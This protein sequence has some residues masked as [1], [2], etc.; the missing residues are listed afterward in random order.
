M[1]LLKSLRRKYEIKPFLLYLL[2]HKWK[3]QDQFEVELLDINIT[4]LLHNS[5]PLIDVGIKVIGDKIFICISEKK[6]KL[7]HW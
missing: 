1:L 6:D 5:H 4:I 7:P 3:H 2:S